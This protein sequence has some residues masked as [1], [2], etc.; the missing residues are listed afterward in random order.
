MGKQQR[1]LE[2][3]VA[4]KARNIEAS[5]LLPLLADSQAGAR[6]LMYLFVATE[7]PTASTYALTENE[8]AVRT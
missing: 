6:G 4:N 5:P 7:K 1:N 8:D 3:V 2:T